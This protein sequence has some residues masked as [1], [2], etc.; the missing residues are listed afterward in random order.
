MSEHRVYEVKEIEKLY[1]RI[2][3]LEKINYNL[4]R[5]NIEQANKLEADIAGRDADE[6][7]TVG[8][9]PDYPEGP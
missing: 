5:D 4:T 3:K 6:G 8:P 7:Y 1:E 2:A 9:Y